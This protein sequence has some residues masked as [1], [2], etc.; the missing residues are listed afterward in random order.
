MPDTSGQ[1]GG[2][3]TCGNGS[4]SQVPYSASTVT[5]AAVTASRIHSLAATEINRCSMRS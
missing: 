1:A 2:G 5:S 4:V 3:I